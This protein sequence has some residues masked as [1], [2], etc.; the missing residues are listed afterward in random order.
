MERRPFHRPMLVVTALGL[1]LVLGCS[2]ES[3][4]TTADPAPPSPEPSGVEVSPSFP[5]DI[6][7]PALPSGATVPV[8]P[9]VWVTRDAISMRSS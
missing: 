5:V 9:S 1:G 6:E 3:P 2:P 7:L 4:P 8:A